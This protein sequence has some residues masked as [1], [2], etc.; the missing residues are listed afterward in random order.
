[1]NRFIQNIKYTKANQGIS[2]IIVLLVISSI[3]VSTLIIG[4]ILIRHARIVKG[5]EMSEKS[6]FAA[7]AAVEKSLYGILQ[8]YDD[9]STFTL[10]G[11]IGSASYEVTSLDIDDDD[12]NGGGDIVCV[13]STCN[14]GGGNNPWEITLSSGEAFQLSVDLNG[15]TYPT[16]LKIEKTTGGSGDS[17]LV[18]YECT[19]DAGPPRVCSSTA[20][21]ANYFTFP[22][23]LT[24]SPT[25]KYY[26]IRINNTDSGSHSY[27]VKPI[28][29]LTTTLPIGVIIN[30]KGSYLSYERRIE[31]NYPKWEEFGI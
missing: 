24:L 16:S 5:V 6:F 29:P 8:N 10:S 14:A 12:P 9:V 31:H 20:S 3:L 1:M 7:E 4:D 23:T 2:L 13:D 18:V 30:A 19:T 26:W 22:Q 15:A 21:Q 27:A 28:V 17:E 11:S 25:T